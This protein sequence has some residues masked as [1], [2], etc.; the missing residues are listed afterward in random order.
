MSDNTTALPE[1]D[2]FTVV[3]VHEFEWTDDFSYH[4]VMA[5]RNHPENRFSSKNPWQRSIFVVTGDCPCPIS[6]FLVLVKN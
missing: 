4:R 5:C 3:P 1:I 6:D 2:G